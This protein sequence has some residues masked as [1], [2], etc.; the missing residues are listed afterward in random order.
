M[1]VVKKIFIGLFVFWFALLLFM[2]KEELFFALEKELKHYD[3][4]IDEER[5][6]ENLL[7]LNLVNAHI[8]VKGIEVATVEK[9]NIFTL[10]FTS[11]I[12]IK[13]LTLDDS[14]KSFAPQHIEVA[15]ISHSLLS[16]M[17]AHIEAKGSFGLLEGEIDL[18]TRTLRVDFTETTAEIAKIRANLKKDEKGLYYETSF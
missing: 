12:N 5:L 10:L 15:N 6:E 1:Q 14:L 18:K 4:V 16:P 13:A 9:M 8:Y 11:N 3:V 17:H 2:P 7:S